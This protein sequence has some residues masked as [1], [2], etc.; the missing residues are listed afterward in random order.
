MKDSPTVPEPPV[1][2]PFS[3]ISNPLLNV[4]VA[5]I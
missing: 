3:L 1:T 5:Y 2:K 4:F